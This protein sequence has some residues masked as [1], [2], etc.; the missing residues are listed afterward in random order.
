MSAPQSRA[1]KRQSVT[2]KQ[3]AERAG[4]SAMT[5][6]RV[7]NNQSVVRDETRTRVE[8]AIRELK[9]RP[10]ILARGLAGGRSLHIGL[11][12][13]NPSHGYLSEFL[14]GALN[15][16][17]LDRHHL[18]IEELSSGGEELER[19]QVAERI[20]ASG[21]D[22]VM[23]PPPLSDNPEVI[24]ALDELELPYAR[25]I[26]CPQAGRGF[27]VT[28]DDV[29]AAKAMTDYLIGAG[30]TRI[31]FIKGAPNHFAAERRLEGFRAAMSAHGLPT[32]DA[33]MAQGHFTYRSGMEAAAVLLAAKPRP[34]AI[35]A[36][37][38]DMAAG[39]IS[40]ALRL[41][42]RV[43]DDLSVVGFDD[44]ELATTIWPQ[45]T[46][47]RQPIAQMAATAVELL[48]RH[49]MKGARF[50]DAHGAR[51]LDVEIIERG[52]VAPPIQ[53]ASAVMRKS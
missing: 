31:G 14:V 30:H 4:V 45:L 41:G 28:I 8:Q 10:N 18:V 53:P 47:V 15:R 42:L 2:I 13:E 35:F 46:T 3:V 40:T 22:A 36:S 29:A 17:R 34:T 20:L 43:P 38:D 7:L 39:A 48:S 1:N 51:L 26:N 37:N 24:D 27:E 21:V 23:L 6:S 12:Y 50:G 49:A 5:V 52:T 19:G 9:Y 11:I 33:A 16:C 25:V 32:P 44:T